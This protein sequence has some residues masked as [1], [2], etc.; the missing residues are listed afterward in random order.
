M[1]GI[2]K[3][4]RMKNNIIATTCILIC[5]IGMGCTKSSGS[6]NFSYNFNSTREDGLAKAL[7]MYQTLCQELARR[8]FRQSGITE[9]SEATRTEYQGEYEGFAVTVKINCL[10]SI[11]ESDPEFS[12]RVS[13]GG[14]SR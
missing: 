2:N 4:T 7:K 9:E 3:G 6:R 8:D 14:G 12:Y 1:T 10:S 5:V 11:S 13:F